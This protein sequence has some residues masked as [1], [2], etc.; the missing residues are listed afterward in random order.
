MPAIVE[1]CFSSSVATAEAMVSGLAPGSSAV[2]WMVG[3][4][5]FGSVD[6]RQQAVRGEPEDQDARHHQHRHDRTA[7]E[8]LA[9]VHDGGS[10]RLGD[11]HAGLGP[12]R[13]W[14]RVTTLLALADRPLATIGALAVGALHLDLAHLGEH[15]CPMT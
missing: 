14:P 13:S 2:T 11:L 10:R 12:R 15:S 6:D 7:D 9:E 4:S 8:Q 3:K 5:T 1:N